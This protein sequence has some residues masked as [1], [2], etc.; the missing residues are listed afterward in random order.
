MK[1]I[2]IP[3]SI[4]KEKKE[5]L[6]MSAQDFLQCQI[7]YKQLFEKLIFS[8]INASRIDDLIHKNHYNIPIVE[9]SGYNFYHKYSKLGSKYLFLRNNIHIERLTLEEINELKNQPGKEFF[10][11][12][13]SRVLFESLNSTSTFF[14]NPSLETKVL[15]NSLVFEF[16]YDLRKIRDMNDYNSINDISN[17]IQDYLKKI[18]IKSGLNISYLEYSSI[19][20]L[21]VLDDGNELLFKM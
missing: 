8:T 18:S 17:A 21:Y 2:F 4:D 12:T 3:D 14:G 15:S 1:Y 10:N 20:D 5:K 9:D 11:K 7:L 16:A 6:G 13:Y 19:P